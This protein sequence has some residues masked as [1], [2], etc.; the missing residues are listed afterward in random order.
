MLDKKYI[1]AIKKS[2]IFKGI[3]VN[4]IE[5]VVKSLSLTT[6]T[7]KKNTFIIK[8]HESIN[9]FGLVIQ[10]LCQIIK[11]DYEGNR[12]IVGEL[13]EGG[14]FGEAIVFS[15]YKECPVSILSKKDT[16]VLWFSRDIISKMTGDY[17]KQFIINIM[18]IIANK[19]VFLNKKIEIVTQRTIREKL[20]TY[21]NYELEKKKTNNFVLPFSKSDLAEYLC[22]ERTS[23]Y[24]VLKELCDDDTIEIDGKKITLLKRY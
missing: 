20:L 21:F 1:S 4:N 3:D 10:G 5:K 11:E 7:Y 2:R 9:T 18:E 8:Q 23:M 24:R 6:E 16:K 12:T 14:F 15:D 17:E 22:V 13:T 19:N